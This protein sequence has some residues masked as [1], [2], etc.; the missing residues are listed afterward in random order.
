MQVQPT[1][2]SAGIATGRAEIVNIH[3]ASTCEELLARFRPQYSANSASLMRFADV[4]GR[5]VYNITRPFLLDGQR[6]IAGRV[7]HRSTEISRIMLFRHHADAWVPH[8]TST[9]LLGL[10]DPCI[11]HIGGELVLG[12]VR[13]PVRA[14][15]GSH[16]WQMEFF[17]GRSL[18]TLRPAFKGPVMM[19]DIRLCELAD[20]RVGV[21]TRPQGPK[22]GRGKI[23]F[24]IAPS[25]SAIS[26]EFIDQ[27]PLLPG[28]FAE[29]EWG[30]ANEAH[31]LDDGALGVLGHIACWDRR[32]NRHYYPVTFQLDPLTLHTTPLQ[33]IARRDS[34]P[35]A[36][37][38]R[39]DLADVVFSGGLERHADGTATL[40]AGL[41]DAAAGQ[42]TLPDPLLPGGA[43]NA[44]HPQP[45]YKYA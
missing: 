36:P 9:L 10:Q 43:P 23:G 21:F 6:L 1:S 44:N 42:L 38:K 26:P 40:Y 35:V 2:A 39:T 20:G 16:G 18:Q 8:F 28:Q 24:A 41:S 13:Y 37:A 31:L 33:I 27:A 12:G 19:K 14:R 32:N 4:D 29:G 34:F 45:V 17:R 30:G 15:D 25:L 11:A 3:R 7:E 5:D 22:G